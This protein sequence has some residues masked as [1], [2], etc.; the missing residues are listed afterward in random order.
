MCLYI[1]TYSTNKLKQVAVILNPIRANL[2]FHNQYFINPFNYFEIIFT[3]NKTYLHIQFQKNKHN[4]LSIISRR[5]NKKLIYY[6]STFK[7]VSVQALLCEKTKSGQM[8][9]LHLESL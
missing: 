9:P 5:S 8:C 6:K 4:A 7:H 2:L 1:S 3:D